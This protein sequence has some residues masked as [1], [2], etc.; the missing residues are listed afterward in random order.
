[1]ELMPFIEATAV[2]LFQI[3]GAFVIGVVLVLLGYSITK[4]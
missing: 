2:N 1:M 3:V 4:P